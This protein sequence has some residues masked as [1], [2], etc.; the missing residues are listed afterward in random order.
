MPTISEPIVVTRQVVRRMLY[1]KKN[2][3]RGDFG[4]CHSIQFLLLLVSQKI[5]RQVA[6]RRVGKCNS[7]L[8]LSSQ[9]RHPL[10]GTIVWR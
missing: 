6:A 2:V 5:M 7:T 1:C 10:M 8:T 3:I 9:R 4:P